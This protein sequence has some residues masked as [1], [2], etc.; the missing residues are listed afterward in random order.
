MDYEFDEA[1][2]NFRIEKPINEVQIS[3]RNYIEQQ[4]NNYI[5]YIEKK[6]FKVVTKIKYFK[7]CY[8][9]MKKLY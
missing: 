1:M 7:L 2:N 6:E 5:I 4:W 3:L 9:I 8:I